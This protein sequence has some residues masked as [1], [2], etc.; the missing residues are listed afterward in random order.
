MVTL[1][2]LSFDVTINAETTNRTKDGLS[3]MAT[4]G[5]ITGGTNSLVVADALDFRVDDWIIVEVGTEAGAAA[6]GTEGVGGAWPPLSY[7]T[8]TAMNADLTKPNNTMCWTRDTGNAYYFLTAYTSWIQVPSNLYNF[9][10]AVPKALVAQ[11]T[12][13]SGTTLTLDRNATVT[14][15]NANVYFDNWGI[16]QDFV[17]TEPTEVAIPAGTFHTSDFFWC[18]QGQSNF[19]FR[20][21]SNTATKIK[22]PLGCSPG[23][24]DAVVC[25]F[26][27]VRDIEFDINERLVGFGLRWPDSRAALAGHGFPAT[28]WF[29]SG[30]MIGN[31]IRFYQSPDC[32]ARDVIIRNPSQQAIMAQFSYRTWAYDCKVFVDDERKMYKQWLYQWIDQDGS[33]I[34]PGGCVRCDVDSNYVIASFEAF[35]SRGVSY[36]QCTGRNALM[37]SNNSDGMIIT[38]MSI[39]I[40][41]DKEVPAGAGNSVMNFNNNASGGGY[42]SRANIVTNPT[43]I[44]GRKTP[45]G[46]RFTA[47][48]IVANV[49]PL[50]V[51]GTYPD[52]DNPKGLLEQTAPWNNE[53]VSG[54]LMRVNSVTNPVT[55]T[56]IRFKGEQPGTDRM[57]RCF[58]N[59][60]MTIT[61]CVLDP[62]AMGLPGTITETGTLT[63]AQYEAL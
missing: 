39:T 63:N 30:L 62:G 18:D 2:N 44:L 51:I 24:F 45:A 58:G 56:G 46:D 3:Q 23:G 11:I 15:T 6:R 59:A 34:D 16:I 31:G 36:L 13:V 43:L 40:E 21:V 54:V 55:V 37:A 48:G 41:D 50:D 12:N 49:A 33:T 17:D 9:N 22:T 14:A 53:F 60:S 35:R 7:A 38:D 32:V 1:A 26:I 28:G 4:T 61:D 57:I 47:I 27:T 52:T 42:A 8:T 5:S 10:M 29:V 25:N 19:T 20:G